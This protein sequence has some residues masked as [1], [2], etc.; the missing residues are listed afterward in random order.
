MHHNSH[1][2]G[3]SV[4]QGENHGVGACVKRV[5]HLEPVQSM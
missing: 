2:L 4:I 5:R 3:Y 1:K